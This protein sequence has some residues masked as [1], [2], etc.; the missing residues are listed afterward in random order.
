MNYY[1]KKEEKYSSS[2]WSGGITKELC[3]YPESSKYLDR[4]F[5]WRIS[6]ATCELE[7]SDFTNLPAYDRV[8]M[9]LEG[10]VILSYNGEKTVKLDE[11]ESDSFDGG[12]KT[13]SYGKILDYNLMVRKGNEGCVD[14]ISPKSGNESFRSEK[15]HNYSS[16]THVLFVKDGYAIVTVDGKQNMVNKGETIVM[17]FDGMEA[18]YEVMGEGTIVRSQIFYND[19]SEELFPEVIP[20]EKATFDDFKLSFMLANTQFRGAKYLFKSL[21]TQWYDEALSKKIN[22]IERLCVTMA[23]YVIMMI[24]VATVGFSKGIGDGKIL[25]N[26]LIWT[27]VDILIVSP[28]IYLLAMPKPIR[29]HI[30]DINNLTG[31]EKKRYEEQS[32][33]SDRTERILKKYK[34][35]GKF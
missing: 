17:E 2:K 34:N 10:S 24:I 7:E 27:A 15:E 11:L 32:G 28:L 33:L 29:K 25:L 5:T 8:L 31:Y 3:I 23:A 21:K 30:K 4:N 26:L 12:W 14:V 35:S 9:V 20:K 16:E 1:V 18:S 13:K 22:K 19:M 6:S